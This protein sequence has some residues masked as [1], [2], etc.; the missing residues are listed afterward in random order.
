MGHLT[1]EIESLGPL[2]FEHS[3]WW[4]KAEPVKVCFTLRLRDKCSKWLEYGC[5]VYLKSYM[6][7]NG[8]C[9]H[10][11][12]G[13]YHKLPLG[14][15]PN[16]QSGDY[17]TSKSHDHQFIIFNHMWRPHMSSILLKPHLVEGLV[18]Y[19]FTLHSPAHDCTNDF[20]SVSG[21]PLDTFFGLSQFHGHGSW[22]VCIGP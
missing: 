18:M 8:S 21:R 14:G 10:G 1:H 19:I 16:T 13:Y 7:S 4:Q 3:G 11:R 17:G 9:V 12:F 15:R 22:F 20:G 5:Q 2:H 6:A